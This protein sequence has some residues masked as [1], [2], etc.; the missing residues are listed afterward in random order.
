M[1]LAD[2]IRAASERPARKCVVC[3]AL[4]DMNT[5][6]ASDLQDCLRDVVVTGAAIA[7]VLRARG[8]AINPDG[9][10]VRRHRK[11]C[12]AAS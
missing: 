7:R 8:Y 11:Y 1:S 4:D 3:D 2:E 10:Q 5:E 9:K 6:D 12:E